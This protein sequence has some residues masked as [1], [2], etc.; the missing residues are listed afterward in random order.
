[1][2]KLMIAAAAAAM[3]GGAYATDVCTD[4]SEAG[5]V[6]CLVYDLQI[7]VK[8]L[9]PK[10]GNCKTKSGCSDGC[11]EIYYLDNTSRTLKGYIWFCDDE[12]WEADDPAHIVLWDATAKTYVV[13][14]GYAYDAD[15]R[16]TK[17]YYE[18]DQL[19]FDFLGRYGKKMT[20]AAASW[21]LDTEYLRGYGAGLNGSLM[22]DKETKEAKLK[23]ISGNFA[24]TVTPSLTIKTA[25]SD[26]TV[27]GV[28]ALLCDCF[29]TICDLTETSDDVPAYGTWSLKY[30]KKLSTGSTPMFKLVP[31]YA[32]FD[33]DKE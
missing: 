11:S 5:G 1:M 28:Y 6:D 24:G 29:E 9:A 17:Y 3:I 21:A 23:S 33:E 22:I 26:E 13:G 31:K 19:A 20:K 16:V 4:E 12:C 15:K 2:K 25:C 32:L 10:Y 30:N 18:T 7:K 14:I 27:E 8:T